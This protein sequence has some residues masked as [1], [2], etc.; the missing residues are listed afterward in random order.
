MVKI[1]TLYF[2]FVFFLSLFLI[3]YLCPRMHRG[4]HI[5]ESILD[6]VA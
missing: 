1:C 5:R 4:V 3:S 6:D 2:V